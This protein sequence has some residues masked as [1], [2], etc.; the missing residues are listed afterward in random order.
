MGVVTAGQAATLAF[1][2]WASATR[3]RWPI[4]DARP[5]HGQTRNSASEDSS[6]L[7]FHWGRSDAPVEARGSRGPTAVP[8]QVASVTPAHTSQQLISHIFCVK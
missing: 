6:S 4:V 2:G 3:T 1:R 5:D 7:D 8:A